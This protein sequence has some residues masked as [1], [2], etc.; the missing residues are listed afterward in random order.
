MAK[1]HF[2]LTTDELQAL[3]QAYDTADD[4]QE[5]RRWQAVRLYGEGWSVGEIKAI[6]GSSESSV[7]RW[8]EHF[9]QRGVDGL[10]SQWQGG[11]RALLTPAQRAELIALVQQTR[12]DALL[13][14]HPR[15]SPTPFW[16]V[17]DLQLLVQA[18][19]GVIWH[20]RTSYITLLHACGLSV[21]RV[22]KQYRSRPTPQAI[23][24]AEMTLEKK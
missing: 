11:N 23:A 22:N 4:P 13:G 8:V 19:Y 12:P 1:R 17:E 5:Q 20:S 10:R 15:R 3:W 16:T 18:R 21:Q 14:S 7:R 9:R 6:T 2:Q 24:E